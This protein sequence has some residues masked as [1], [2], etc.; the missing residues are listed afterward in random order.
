MLYLLEHLLHKYKK[1][2]VVM[3]WLFNLFSIL[4]ALFGGLKKDIHAVPLDN[5]PVEDVCGNEGGGGGNGIGVIPPGG[6]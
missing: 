5:N 2:E 3:F 4:V 1:K 6:A